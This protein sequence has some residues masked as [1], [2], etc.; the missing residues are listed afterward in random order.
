MSITLTIAVVGMLCTVFGLVG[1][2]LWR[3]GS[4]VGSFELAVREAKEQATAAALAAQAAVQRAETA[5]LQWNKE[6]IAELRDLQ[7]RVDTTD[8]KLD[9]ERA[10]ARRTRQMFDRVDSHERRITALESDEAS[11]RHFEDLSGPIRT[12]DDEESEDE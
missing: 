2:A 8:R 10:D 7:E 1:G 11:R 12:T 3:L 5:G 6:L 4:R 9:M